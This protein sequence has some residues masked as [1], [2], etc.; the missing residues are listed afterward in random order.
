[1][2]LVDSP[3]G[4]DFVLLSDSI[5]APDQTTVYTNRVPD[6]CQ[7]DIF[8]QRIMGSVVDY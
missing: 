2:D 4:P 1:L 6:G 8:E 3:T 5:V 7:H